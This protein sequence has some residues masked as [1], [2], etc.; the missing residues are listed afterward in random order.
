MTFRCQ[1][2]KLNTFWINFRSRNP[3]QTGVY[4]QVRPMGYGPN[5][6]DLFQMINNSIYTTNGQDKK[7]SKKGATEDCILQHH[8]Q[9][10]KKREKYKRLER[11]KGDKKNCDKYN[12]SSERPK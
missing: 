11:K 2:R 8:P 9:M 12:S 7:K 5:F 10:K 1:L 4:R 6:A 3:R